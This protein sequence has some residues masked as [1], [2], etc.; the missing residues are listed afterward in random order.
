MG[1]VD[2]LLQRQIHD[3]NVEPVSPPMEPLTDG[4]GAQPA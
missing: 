1:P 2:R 3:Q 4:P